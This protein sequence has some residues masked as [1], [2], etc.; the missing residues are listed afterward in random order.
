MPS[1]SLTKFRTKKLKNNK[2]MAYSERSIKT[3]D[4]ILFDIRQL[5]RSELCQMNRWLRNSWKIPLPVSISGRN[6]IKLLE[7]FLKQTVKAT[8]VATAIG[9]SFFA[10]KCQLDIWYVIQLNWLL[11]SQKTYN[12]YWTGCHLSPPIFR[13]SALRDGE[14]IA[15]IACIWKVGAQNSKTSEEI[16]KFYGET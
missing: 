6:S 14:I 12:N 9:L 2:D 4:N 7:K 5:I 13:S 10:I 1:V 8:M 16:I 15:P 3:A 11:V